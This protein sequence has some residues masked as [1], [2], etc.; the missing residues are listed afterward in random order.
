MKTP[1]LLAK[2]A[3]DLGWDKKFPV[4]PKEIASRI[5][6]T[7]TYVSG[8]KIDIPITIFARNHGAETASW[9]RSSLLLINKE[10]VFVC[11]FNS[12]VSSFLKSFII[13]RHLYYIMSGKL[14]N[15]GDVIED[16]NFDLSTTDVTQKEANKFALSLLMPEF[17]VRHYY[18]SLPP[19]YKM[20]M[21]FNVSEPI[22]LERLKQ[23]NLA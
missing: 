7:R 14:T 1:V 21:L 6:V 13:S 22:M 3:L 10:P 2:R 4:S 20:S 9:A 8:K 15:I 5:K 23:L 11:E 16:Y 18:S 17:F 19:L 12:Y